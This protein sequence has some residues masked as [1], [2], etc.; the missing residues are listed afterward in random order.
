MR[1]ADSAVY[2]GA[3]A[4]VTINLHRLNQRIQNAIRYLDAKDS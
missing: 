2:L 3:A 4:S 1:C